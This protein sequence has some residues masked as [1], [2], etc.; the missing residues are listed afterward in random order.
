MAKILGK[1]DA[2]ALEWL[3]TVKGVLP[4]EL[5]EIKESKKV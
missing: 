3:A 4:K 1:A 2:K 5:Y